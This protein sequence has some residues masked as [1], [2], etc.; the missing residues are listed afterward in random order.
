MTIF[1]HKKNGKL[2][3]IEMVR[4]RRRIT[5]GGGVE[6]TP[7]NHNVTLRNVKLDDFV[8]VSYR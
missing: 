5:D 7:F 4:R 1:R 8:A 2:Y 6:A 3:T